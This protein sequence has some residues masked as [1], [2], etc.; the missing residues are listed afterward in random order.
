MKLHDYQ[1]KIAV[2]FLRQHDRAGLFLDMG[3]GKTACVLAALEPRHLPALVIA[4]KRV[5][6]E[7]WPDESANWRPDLT[8]GLAAGGPADRKYVLQSTQDLTVI[9]QDNVKD[10]AAVRHKFNTLVID[11]SSGYKN[12]ASKRFEIANGLA[13][14]TNHVWILTGTPAPNGYL[15]LWSQIYLLDQGKRLGHNITTYRD[16]WFFPKRVDSRHVVTEWG[17]QNGAE[18]EIK[19]LIEDICLYMESDGRVKLPPRVVNPITLHLP[20][21]VMRFY[22]KLKK[23]M[24]ADMEEIGLTVSADNAGILSNR[25]SQVA[26]GF[27]YET[28]PIT[29]E[30]TTTPVHGER[31]KIVQSILDELNGAT[32]LVAY[33]YQEEERQ[34]LALPGARSIREKGSIADWNRGDVPILV[35]HPASAG[36]GLNLQY[37]GHNIIWTSPTWQLELWLQMNKRLLRQGQ[38]KPVVIHTITAKGTVDKVVYDR[39]EKKNS[40]QNGL[41]EHL[42]SP[43]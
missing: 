18:D 14:R 17:T 12:Y 40:V 5:A 28:D 8:F 39:L 9:G 25:L 37:G 30:R 32:A 42:R 36:H 38:T 11:E 10:L 15:D 2:P 27:I 19:G 21:P 1:E 4:P 23:D 22:R 24:V 13:L 3:L 33:R 34:L 7:T 35:A 16:R 43:V 41:L 29:M 20:H 31:I 6:E 26:S